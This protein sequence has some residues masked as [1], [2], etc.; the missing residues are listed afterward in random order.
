MSKK[1]TIEDIRKKS[2][3]K[4]KIIY[5]IHDQ[6]FQNNKSKIDFICGKCGNTFSQKINSHLNGNGC[7]FCFGTHKHTLEEI[8]KKSKEIHNNI[9]EIKEQDFINGTS[10]IEIYCKKCKKTFKQTILTHL[11]KRIRGCPHCKKSK[12]EN[13]I[14][15]YLIQNNIFFITQ[16]RFNDCRNK[17]PLPFDFYLPE[18]NTCI[19]YDGELHYISK[20]YFG[21]DEKLKE[22]QKRDEIK[23]FYCKENNINLIRIKYDENVFEKMK[24]FYEKL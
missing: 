6:E 3:D 19:E 18:Y 7:P 22:T 13:D 12:G 15:K 14:E 23:T 17:L 20:E 2:N 1:L 5:T 9:Y 21:G 11:D 10:K 16:K 24:L 4:H 8:R